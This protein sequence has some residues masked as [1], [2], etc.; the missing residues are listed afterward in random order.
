MSSTW[1][2]AASTWSAMSVD[3]WRTSS[4]T[5]FQ[6]SLNR[7]KDVVA[8]VRRPCLAQLTDEFRSPVLMTMAFAARGTAGLGGAIGGTTGCAPTTHANTNGTIRANIPSPQPMVGPSV[9]ERPLIW[10]VSLFPGGDPLGS[11]GEFLLLRSAFLSTLAKERSGS[12]DDRRAPIGGA[13]QGF[14]GT[15]PR[16]AAD[17]QPTSGHPLWPNAVE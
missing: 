7:L 15:S 2:I 5:T 14:P 8:S 1:A 17:R 3:C 10:E 6:S 4:S 9:Y 16:S 12:A 11:R 13:P